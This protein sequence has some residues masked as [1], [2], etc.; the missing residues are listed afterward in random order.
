MHSGRP[1]P[2]L[3]VLVAPD[4][5][6]GSLTAVE[7]AQALADGWR[8]ARP[9]D[10]VRLSPLADGGEGTIAAVSAAS[11][12]TRLP[13]AGRDP[14]GRE[15]PAHFLR[16]GDRGIVEL[17]VASGLSR[18]DHDERDPLNASTFG[19]GLVVAAAIGLGVRSLV[20]GLGG[21]ATTDGGSGILTALGARFLDA[22][23]DDLPP[24]GASLRQLDS[25]DLSGIAP[26]LS[27]VHL[28][29]ASDVTNPLLG[30]L[31][32]AAVYGPQKGAKEA[33]IAL[34]DAALERYATVLEHATGR[35]IRS[36]RG[37]GAAGGTT[38][39]L[40]AIADR[41]ASFEIRPGVEVVMELTGFAEALVDASLV[42]TGEGR[43]DDQTG[44]GKTVLGVAQKAAQARR[45]CICFGGSVTPAGMRVLATLGAVGVP[46]TE[47]P[48]TLEEQ[49]QAGI[50]PIERAADRTSRL[51]SLVRSLP[52]NGPGPA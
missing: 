51:V 8:R 44:H 10:E 17:A 31:G 12:W 22:A 42:L 45:P 14:L 19:T 34:L 25:V 33:E 9:G 39:G 6:K 4:A 37:S 18:L 21:S 1:T 2:P 16:A 5:F 36:I 43:I 32:A 38:A 27:E 20:L 11:G 13:A 15:L 52:E 48:A 47:G 46:V 49:I 7:V 50:A 30:E 23:G 24:G 40:L 35:S 26:V 3:H 29:V 41:F 28:T